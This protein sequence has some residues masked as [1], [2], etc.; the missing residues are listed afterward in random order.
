VKIGV[1]GSGA[2][3]TLFAGLLAAVADVTLLGHW[4]D[5]MAALRWKGLRL[6]MADGTTRHVHFDLAGTP[7]A[8]VDGALILVK[9][10]QTARAAAEARR[11][12]RPAG[13]ALTLQ[14]GL[15]HVPTL[16]AA[17][18][19]K[20]VLQGVTVAGATV[21]APGHTR[22]SGT[23]AVSVGPPAGAADAGLLDALSAA[24]IAVHVVEN[25][26]GVVWG[27]VA[28]N[29][30]INPPTALLDVDNGALADAAGG[31]ELLEKAAGEVAAVAAALNIPL[32]FPDAGAEAIRVARATATN[33]SSMRQDL[34]RDAPT[35]IG[36]ICGA[37]VERAAWAGVPVP[38]NRLYARLIAAAEQRGR[39]NALAGAGA[40]A[41]EA[42]FLNKLRSLREEGETP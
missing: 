25:I 23:P 17:L 27:K 39:G 32:P 35:E 11:W 8:P 20:R 36:A 7:A 5:Q 37:V 34:N 30:A 15:G 18:G 13:I 10:G 38:L 14:N 40:D 29:A 2:M 22:Q 19:T 41:T 4:P 21:V 16:R 6:E 12:L 9:S 26:T 3:G 24:G 31:R 28:I 1:I 33:H 42:P